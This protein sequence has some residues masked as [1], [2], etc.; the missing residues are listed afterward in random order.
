MLLC[1]C[2]GIAQRWSP[3]GQAGFHLSRLRQPQEAAQGELRSFPPRNA[4]GAAPSALPSHTWGAAMLRQ[5]VLQC[6]VHMLRVHSKTESQLLRASS[7]NPSAEAL[8][9]LSLRGEARRCLN[10]SA[11]SAPVDDDARLLT[12]SMGAELR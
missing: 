5:A 9:S 12:P 8:I 7:C 3:R 6:L 11:G 4:G 1:S 2:T 10:H